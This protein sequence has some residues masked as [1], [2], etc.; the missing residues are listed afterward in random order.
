MPTSRTTTRAAAAAR[1]R[2]LDEL[3]DDHRRVQ[4]A[5]RQFRKLDCEQD[6]AA[7]E[8]IVQQTLQELQ[9][10]AALE[11]ELLY[12]AARGSIADDALVD[13]AEVEHES[14]HALIARLLETT[15]DDPKYGARFVVLCEYVQHHV[16][17]EEREL[18]PQLE[19]ARLDWEALAQQMDDRRAEL[20]ADPG[21]AA[22]PAADKAAPA[23]DDE[24]PTTGTKSMPRGPDKPAVAAT[25]RTI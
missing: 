5:Y 3:K 9:V 25:R 18:F 16:R 14:A 2:I 7:C 11:E 24:A 22:L 20:A 6:P 4:K 21:A 1:T 12:P 17:E 23:I 10:H 8:A 19:R 13:E 15:A